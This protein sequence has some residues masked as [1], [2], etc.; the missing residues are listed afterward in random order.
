MGLCRAR[1]LR[2]GSDLLLYARRS[3][4]SV[5]ST[6]SWSGCSAGWCSCREV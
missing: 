5:S 4:S 2:R 6:C 1:T 3:Y